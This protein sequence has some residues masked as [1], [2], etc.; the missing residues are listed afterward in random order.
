ME[1]NVLEA[2][3]DVSFISASKSNMGK[4]IIM[5]DHKTIGVYNSRAKQYADLNTDSEI[6][7]S[8]QNFLEH[9]PKQAR[10]LDWGCGP[11]IHSKHMKDA[12]YLPDPIDASARM[13]ALAQEKYDLNA[14]VG[15]FDDK[16]EENYHGAWVNFSLLHVSRHDFKKH[17]YQLYKALLSGGVLHLGMKRGKGE[18][19]DRLQRFYTFYE[20]LELTTHLEEAGF[21]IIDVEEGVGTGLAG[22]KDP[23]VLILSKKSG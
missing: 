22:S 9:L 15:A 18:K 12:G 20:T 8:L 2:N 19:R 17:L 14:R 3:I 7:H 13:V 23:F 4:C 16:L 6:H 21:D 1:G 11:G 5:T 10:I